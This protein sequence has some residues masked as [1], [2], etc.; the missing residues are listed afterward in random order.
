MI[1]TSG[2]ISGQILMRTFRIGLKVGT[3]L[4]ISYAKQD[5]FSS[6]GDA[7]GIIRHALLRPPVLGVYKDINDPTYNGR[8]SLY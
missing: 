1:N 2:L 6:S 7:P 4:Q 8:Q 3:N 5:K